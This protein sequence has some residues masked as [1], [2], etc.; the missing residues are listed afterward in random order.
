MDVKRKSDPFRDYGMK[1]YPAEGKLL[2]PQKIH[3]GKVSSKNPGQSYGHNQKE[4]KVVRRKGDVAHLRDDYPSQEE[5]GNAEQY[6]DVGKIESGH[7]DFKKPV[8]AGQH[9]HRPRDRLEEKTQMS[10]DDKEKGPM[11]NQ[12]G[13]PEPLRPPIKRPFSPQ[14][15]FGV[16][17]KGTE[18]ENLKKHP[19]DDA[20]CI[21]RAVEKVGL[22]PWKGFLLPAGRGDAER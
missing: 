16:P 7:P 15:H 20:G 14:F 8:K 4:G 5:V 11:K 22:D 21:V 10:E 13:Q 6:G 19:A 2:H 17:E 1:A 3:L 12:P 18:D 9:I